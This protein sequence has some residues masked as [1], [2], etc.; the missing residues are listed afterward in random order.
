MSKRI[1]EEGIEELKPKKR[2]RPSKMEK[3]GK[4]KPIKKSKSKEDISEIEKLREENYHLQ[5]EVE[6]L[7]KVQFSQMTVSEMKCQLIIT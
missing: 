1:K 2:G 6:I 4:K 7:K 5:M 3:E